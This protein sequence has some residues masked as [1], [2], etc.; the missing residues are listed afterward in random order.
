MRTPSSRVL[1]HAAA[2]TAL[3]AAAPLP[4]Q[5]AHPPLHVHRGLGDCSVHF[6]PT[7]TQGAFHRFVREFGSVSA[8]RQVAPPGT[9]G[10]GRVLL[11]VEMIRFRIDDRSDAWNDTF[12]HPDADHPLGSTQ[13]FPKLRL[14]VG[15]SDALDVGVSY[16]ENF[17]A[18]YGWLGLDG[19]YALLTEREGRP[20]SLAVRGA[21]TRTLRVDDMD[22]HA[23]TADVSV[24]R[25]VRRGLR[26]YA[27]LGADGV[28][29]RETS[30]AVDLRDERVVVPHLFGG[31]DAA[32]GRRVSVGAE[33][34][35]GPR[36]T[37]HLQVGAV[38]F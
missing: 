10:K 17:S 36:P 16:T 29:A 21:Y 34:T 20:V 37:A 18:N 8:F 25:R 30:D 13:S 4:A 32:V 22:M 19:K 23:L 7:L 6:A 15:V 5:S 12:A 31:V 38:A 26:A 33:F 27:G 1:V 3:V 9:L 24:G 11:G 35:L 2:V 28:F 14:R